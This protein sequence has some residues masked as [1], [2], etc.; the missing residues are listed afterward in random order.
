MN[1]QLS[2]QLEMTVKMQEETVRS[3][4]VE[5][6][7]Q[8]QE[9]EHWRKVVDEM[10]QRVKALQKDLEDE[11]IQHRTS[12]Q[13]SE[14]QANQRDLAARATLLL[15]LEELA[16]A[17][18]VLEK[19]SESMQELQDKSMLATELANLPSRGVTSYTSQ[20]A[21]TQMR[22]L[23]VAV[24]ISANRLCL[25]FEALV[26]SL[27]LLFRSARETWQNTRSCIWSQVNTA[28][29]SCTKPRAFEVF[30]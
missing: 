2:S 5:L 19:E 25:F 11:K 3:F 27:T 10:R 23:H 21:R 1:L 20:N 6:K 30:R 18:S 17:F 13:Q 7:A 14:E 8:E 29:T 22:A 12:K 16:N 26:L 28:D 4:I 15:L 24:Y 9:C